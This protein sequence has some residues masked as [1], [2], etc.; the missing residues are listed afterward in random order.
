MKSSCNNSKM[1]QTITTLNVN[2]LHTP[3]KSEIQIGV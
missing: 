2:V 1:T 3:S